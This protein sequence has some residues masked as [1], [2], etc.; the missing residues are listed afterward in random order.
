MDTNILIAIL[1]L[2]PAGLF[3]YFDKK[4]LISSKIQTKFK[5][6]NFLGLYL[7]ILITLVLST[8]I[9]AT[10]AMIF[11]ISST[12]TYAIQAV[13]IGVLLGLFSNINNIFRIKKRV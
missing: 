4:L 12:F 2:V 10:L 6:N 9:V 3:I 11:H 5:I 8:F 1:L 7:F 13:L